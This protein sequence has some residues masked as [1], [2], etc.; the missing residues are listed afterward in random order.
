MSLT[1]RH[2]SIALRKFQWN[3]IT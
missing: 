2:A 3:T 1:I